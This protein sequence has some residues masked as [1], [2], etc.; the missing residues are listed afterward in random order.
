MNWGLSGFNVSAI[1]LPEYEIEYCS[2]EA[3]QMCQKAEV[4]YSDELEQNMK[5]YAWSH[6]NKLTS[7]REMT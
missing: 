6:I 4:K 1:D 3:D 7:H 2:K 5:S